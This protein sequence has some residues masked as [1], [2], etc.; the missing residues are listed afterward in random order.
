MLLLGQFLLKSAHLSLDHGVELIP[1]PVSAVVVET[2]VPLDGGDAL[3]LGDLALVGDVDEDAASLALHLHK[4]LGKSSLAD[5]LEGGQHT[6]AEHDLSL[7]ATEGVGVHAGGN[8]S[9]GSALTWVTG[10]V[11]EDLGGDDGVT[12]HEI[13][14]G[15]LVGQTQHANTDALQHA[16]AVELVHDERSVDVSRLL[17]LVGDDAA[18]EVRG[19]RVQVGHQLHQ[20]LSVSSRDGHHG[21]ALLLLA[22]VLLGKDESADGIS[23]AG[24]HADHSLVHGILVLEEPAGN[25]VSDGTGVMMDLKMS[26]GLALFGGLGLAERLVLAQ[27]FAHHLLQVGLIGGLGHNALLLQHGQDAHLLLDQLDG[28]DQI[29]AKINESPLDALGLVLFLLL[30][31]HVVVEKLLETLVGV[32]DEELFQDVE[33][34]DLEAGDVQY[35]DKILPG[36]G[37]VQRVVDQGDDPIE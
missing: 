17:D 37:R 27:M 25:I 11:G 8:E 21:G 23:G 20:R 2:D 13:R 30:D 32:V 16:V 36:I 33:L 29:H 12:G 31:E 5:L 19:S 10:H 9:L 1:G 15:D 7:A 24:H 4:D 28:L 34:E 22:G 3:L 26:L 35:A 18:D 14:V 6:G